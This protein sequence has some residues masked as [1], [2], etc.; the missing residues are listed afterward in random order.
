MSELDNNA[1]GRER[2]FFIAVVGP[3]GSGKTALGVQLAKALGSQ[4]ISADSQLVY[5]GLDIGTAKP[6]FAER[7]GVA[8]HMIDLVSP[9]DDSFT[10]AGYRMM[11]R[12]IL[13]DLH[14]QHKIPVVVGGTGFYVRALLDAPLAPDVTPDPAFRTQ[15]RAYLE[16][17]GELALHRLLTEKDPRRA[18]QVH[19]RNTVRVIRALEIINA[20]GGPVPEMP[21]PDVTQALW[22][23]LGYSQRERM[24]QRIDQ[25]IRAMLAAGW[26]EEVESLLVRYG[27]EAHALKVAHGYPE[28]VEVCQGNCSLSSA[29]KQLEI[30]IHQYATRQETW[31]RHQIYRPKG[32]STE[33]IRWFDVDQGPFDDVTDKALTFV[34]E[35]LESLS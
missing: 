14:R 25:R 18:S 23:G 10:V 29:I 35:T 31:Y 3:T 4:V 19:P 34:N 28:L 5:R 6:T 1:I 30:N 20:L 21:Q 15:M 22:V 17:N 12:E 32:S 13:N 26:Q 11:G 33:V 2:P 16:A 24:R 9:D 7:Q 27:K 8:H